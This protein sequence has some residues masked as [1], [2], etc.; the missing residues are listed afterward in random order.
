MLRERGKR[1][2]VKKGKR[3]GEKKTEDLKI[4]RIRNTNR[5]A[6]KGSCQVTIQLPDNLVPAEH[7]RISHAN[8]SRCLEKRVV[9]NCI[10]RT[11]EEK[12]D[13]GIT[14]A[15]KSFTV[16]GWSALSRTFLQGEVELAQEQML[17]VKNCV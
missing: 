8:H 9:P 4:R 6:Q 13:K 16:Q 5:R 11:V 15:P 1:T 2:R 12:I 3:S 10:A 17:I 7:L 14:S